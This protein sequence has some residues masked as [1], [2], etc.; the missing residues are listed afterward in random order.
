MTSKPPYLGV[1]KL[2]VPWREATEDQL[3]EIGVT[4]D[5]IRRSYQD[6]RSPEQ[7]AK[8]LLDLY[9]ADFTLRKNA[10]AK[11]AALEEKLKQEKLKTAV[12]TAIITAL[13]FKGIEVL[14]VWL[15]NA[16]R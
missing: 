16:L 1:K 3:K 14:F 10:D 12:L 15:M 11:Y 4:K 5:Q 8:D 2:R 7:I 9:D 13:A 6:P